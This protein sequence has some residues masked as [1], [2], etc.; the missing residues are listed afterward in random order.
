MR[1]YVGCS[2][3]FY[4][5]W[6]GVFYPPLLKREDYIWFYSKYFEVVEINSSFYNFPNRGTVKSMLSRTS[7]LKFAFKAHRTFTHSRSY[8]QEDVK[9][10]L[11]ALEPALEEDRFIALLFQFPESFG[12]KEESLE[13]LNKLS[14]DFIGLSKVI[15]VR[16]KSFKKADFYHLLEELGFSLVNTDAPKGSKFLVGPWVGVGSINYLRFHGRDPDH[17]YDYLYSLEELKKLKDKVKKLGN[18][19]TYIFFNNTVRAKAVL[20]AL[21]FKLLFGIKAEVPK[22]LENSLKEKE[23]E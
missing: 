2:G 13:Y 7:T 9:K 11:Y 3:F 4:R 20:N 17:I 18:K 10:F 5:D 8:R 23:W 19:D 15:E 21:Q 22:S 14:K 12:Y 16:N 1:V 6:V